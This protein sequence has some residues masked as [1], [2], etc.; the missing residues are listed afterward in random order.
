[1][2]SQSQVGNL[3]YLQKHGENIFFKSQTADNKKGK[4]NEKYKLRRK[5]SAGQYKT[6]LIDFEILYFLFFHGSSLI[7]TYMLAVTRNR[8]NI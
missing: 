5:P 1:M 8:Y 6:D 4:N 2:E 3:K 7:F